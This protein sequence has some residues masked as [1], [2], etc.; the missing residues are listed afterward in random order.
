[1]TDPLPSSPS[2][3]A[4][5]AAVAAPAPVIRQYSC[6]D[7]AS[8]RNLVLRITSEERAHILKTLGSSY[9]AAFHSTG[10]CEKRPIQI[11]S[12]FDVE[13]GQIRRAF[14]EEFTKVRVATNTAVAKR[15]LTRGMI[16][17]II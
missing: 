6:A 11:V 8:I 12:P 5:A 9:T 13:P 2:V 14:L 10:F 4:V 1:M 17:Y 3:N 15:F 16:S 7:D